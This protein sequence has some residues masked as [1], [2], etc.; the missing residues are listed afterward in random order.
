MS[1]RFQYGIV[2]PTGIISLPAKSKKRI[3]RPL[4]AKRVAPPFLLPRPENS[5]SK[6]ILELEALVAFLV[7]PRVRTIL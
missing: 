1:S 6:V 5:F 7:V 3:S 4:L 2:N